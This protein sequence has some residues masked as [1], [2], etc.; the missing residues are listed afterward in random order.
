GVG[1]AISPA[2]GIAGVARNIGMG[3]ASGTA[4]GM[5]KEGTGSD[6]AAMAVG[7]ATP[8]AVRGAFSSGANAPLLRNPVKLATAQEGMAAGYVVPPSYLKPSFSTN[9]IESISGKAA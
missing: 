6:L 3:I 4:A 7:M 2:S 8:F 1:T 9:R 5:T